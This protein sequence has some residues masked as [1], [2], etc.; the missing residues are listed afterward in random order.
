MNPTSS[1]DQSTSTPEINHSPNLSTSTSTDSSS[2]NGIPI[3]TSSV[4][5]PHH[6]RSLSVNL[7]PTQA[8]I[9]PS[10]KP[11]QRRPSTL[12]TT[13][14]NNSISRIASNSSAS[15]SSST[16]LGLG[17]GRAG[18]PPSTPNAPRSSSRSKIL[19]SSD[20]AG[21]DIESNERIR[22]REREKREEQERLRSESQKDQDGNGETGDEVKNEDQDQ[23]GSLDEV[24]RVRTESGDQDL[25]SSSSSSPY[26]STFSHNYSPTAYPV[27]NGSS[28]NRKG[29]ISARP[30][31]EHTTSAGSIRSFRDESR[32]RPSTATNA[33][34]SPSLGK[35]P[36]SS[37]GVV[38]TYQSSPSGNATPSA[39]SP[40][41]P[42][43]FKD[44]SRRAKSPPVPSSATFNSNLNSNSTEQQAALGLSLPGSNGDPRT[45]N[46]PARSSS[47]NSSIHSS[48]P[49]PISS[50]SSSN[51]IREPNSTPPQSQSISP[52]IISTPTSETSNPSPTSP[53]QSDSPTISTSKPSLRTRLFG[54]RKKKGL[55][56]PASLKVN[57]SQN[58][59]SQS[60]TSL[61]GGEG[62][63]QSNGIG[64][65]LRPSS[66]GMQK[67]KSAISPSSSFSREGTK[68]A[69]SG[70][71]DFSKEPLPP[72]PT[73]SDAG[74][75]GSNV[76][77][78]TKRF[79]GGALRNLSK[80][81]KA[82]EK[83]K[84]MVE[85]IPISSS[86]TLPAQES[87]RNPS[88]SIPNSNS[89]SSELSDSTGNSHHSDTSGISKYESSTSTSAQSHSINHSNGIQ[90]RNQVQNA[91]PTSSRPTTGTSLSTI[92]TKTPSLVSSPTSPSFLNS[93]DSAYSY[94]ARGFSSNSQVSLSGRS[95]QTVGARRPRKERESKEERDAQNSKKFTNGTSQSSIGHGGKGTYGMKKSEEL[96]TVGKAG[97]SRRGS[98]PPE[99]AVMGSFVKVKGAGEFQ[100]GKSRI[101]FF[102]V[103]GLNL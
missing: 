98:W 17:L 32:R 14:S 85:E 35:R 64:L 8:S 28:S 54:S 67:S 71:T 87:S 61:V 77:M 88:L 2:L 92:S 103:F 41:V 47:Y 27:I 100:N 78:L 9:S 30:E 43:G 79:G 52:Q 82:K 13:S 10:F 94:S 21:R 89:N 86:P 84:E 59:F 1:N 15:I 7:S 36:M 95:I 25:A 93:E 90:S 3:P 18:S 80:K 83:E 55:E 29:S 37:A 76:S 72:M 26:T 31:L 19:A 63:E 12:S 65:G 38:G 24:E 50:S 48:N 102:L 16:N 96:R 69:H 101:P 74:E 46:R 73:S 91:T 39:T 45:N 42:S 57:P 70:K 23:V 22:K 6:N 66:I 97:L 68:S 81:G 44:Y 40:T 56:E 20:R 60:R 99:G 51:S 53:F 4:N 75:E 49:T 33:S 5:S 62:V 11:H 58:F 34:N